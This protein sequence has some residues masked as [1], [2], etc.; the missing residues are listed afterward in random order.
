MG[1]DR[2][3]A[4]LTAFA[5]GATWAGLAGVVFASQVT[6]INPT[7]F[8]FMQSVM[9]LSIVVL[10]GMGSIPGVV[11]GAVVLILLPEYLRPFAEYRMLIF[12][13]AMVVMMVFRPGGLIQSVREVY[14]YK[15]SEH[16]D[17]KEAAK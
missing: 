2:T 13:A 17:M 16:E 4:K 11:I 6:F 3:R 12:G 15:P 14:V 9:I 1:I 10:G 5:L 8:T 7:S